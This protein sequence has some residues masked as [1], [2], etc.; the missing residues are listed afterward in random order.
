M[1]FFSLCIVLVLHKIPKLS[2]L[3][4]KYLENNLKKN[5]LE[6]RNYPQLFLFSLLSICNCPSILVYTFDV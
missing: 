4:L 1:R 6:N 2:F 3:Y 5:F